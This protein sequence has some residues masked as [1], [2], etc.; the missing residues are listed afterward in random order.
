MQVV[1]LAGGLATRMHPETV[2]VPKSLLEVAG[3]PFVDWQLELL[4]RSGYDDVVLCVG[5]L[6][7]R[8]RAHVGSGDRFGVRVRYVFDGPKLL[9]TWGALRG[10]LSL[11]DPMFLVT[12]GDSYLPFDYGAPLRMLG[13]REDCDGV[14]SVYANEGRWDASNV[15]TDGEWVLRYEKGGAASDLSFIDYGALALRRAVVARLQMGTPAGLDVLQA[16]LA[17]SRRLCACVATERFFEIGSREGLA[18]LEEHL[19]SARGKPTS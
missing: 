5:H 7:D 16:E 8:V 14:M 19:L 6:G 3:R 17:R 10:A 4:A 13:A 11:L 1:V 2:T 12:Y 15:A 9:G 18:A